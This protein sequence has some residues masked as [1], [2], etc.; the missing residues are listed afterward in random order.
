MVKRITIGIEN[1][2]DSARNGY[3]D[4]TLWDEEECYHDEYET[5]MDWINAELSFVD[6]KY[7]ELR[8]LCDELGLGV[9]YAA[10][11]FCKKNKIFNELSQKFD[12][13]R[14]DNE[15]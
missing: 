6:N 13:W 1:A 12:K 14:K 4:S 8:A 5:Y 11:I 10:N 9:K 15:R 7:V 2:L 3:H